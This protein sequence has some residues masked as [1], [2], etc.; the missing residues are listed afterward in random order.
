MPSHSSQ[1]QRIL[2]GGYGSHAVTGFDV[3]EAAQLPSSTMRRRWRVFLGVFLFALLVGMGFTFGRSPEY[4]ATA[5]L[6][7]VPAKPAGASEAA[8]AQAMSAAYLTELQVL[9]SRPLLEKVAQ[10][11]S[12]QGLN[13]PD[14]PV[15]TDAQALQQMLTVT[16]LEGTQVLHLQ[17]QSGER[18]L[19]APLLNTLIAVY[20]D[21]QGDAGKVNVE[22]QL[23]QASE[24]LRVIESKV[25]EKRR[26]LDAFRLKSNIDSSE[27]EDDPSLARQKGLAQSLQAATDREAIAA[28]KVRSLEQSSDLKESGRPLSQAKDNPTVANIEARLSQ[29]REDLRGLERQFTQQYLEMDPNVRALKT[30]IANLEQQLET[31]R[32]KGQQ[33]A[34][35]D[36]KEELASARATV[37]RL[38]QQSAENRQGVQNFNRRFGEFQGLQDELQGLEKMQLAAR[39]KLL[40]M[41]ASEA[42]QRPGLVVLEPAVT[43]VQAWRP[44]YV[45]DAG[46]ALLAALVVALLSVGLVEFLSREQAPPVQPSALL[47]APPW[48][49]G[50]QHHAAL[51]A[52]R[53]PPD[54]MLDVSSESAA[55]DRFLAPPLPRELSPDEIERLLTHAASSQRALL[56]GLLC[57]LTADELL[58]LPLGA[59]NVERRS[60]S[61]GG[62]AARELPLPRGLLDF[63][64][65]QGAS[66]EPSRPLF[67]RP[68]GTGLEAGDVALAVTASAYDAQLEQ[69]QSISPETLR[70][71]YLAYLVRQGL[72]FSELGL[73][74]GRLDPEQLK[75]LAALSP[76]GV[77]VGIDQ[78]R[79][80]MPQLEL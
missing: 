77:R 61:V 49:S 56:T 7:I 64:L 15:A 44:L 51:S 16:P 14:R 36:A 3:G 13:A 53:A 11:L 25:L 6:Q 47:I 45:R 9:S 37:H 43:P 35:A 40:A 48:L 66:A 24:E 5:R 78:I 62:G 41:Q 65:Q 21:E 2:V 73:L 32:H 79:P 55:G 38:Q 34:L 54:L 17:A 10:R 58:G 52:R 50:D 67:T 20:R 75:G 33:S 59:V 80:T 76:E 70:H 68:D 29:L 39:Q 46:I 28:G 60:L 27:R 74:A 1:P 57:G 19:V 18:A 26:T 12:A 23:Q 31:E 69:A 72:R 42:L 30:R 4:M 63:A 22:A 71:T 8:Q